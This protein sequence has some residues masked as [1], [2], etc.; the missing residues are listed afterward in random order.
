M[1]LLVKYPLED[2]SKYVD[3]LEILELVCLPGVFL[4]YE[5]FQNVASDVG[6]NQN[7][8]VPSTFKIQGALDNLAQ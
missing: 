7:F 3:D 4:D 8:L 6:I 5:F 1:M 2:K